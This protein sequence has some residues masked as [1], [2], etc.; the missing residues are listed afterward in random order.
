M[1]LLQNTSDVLPDIQVVIRHADAIRKLDARRGSSSS[2]S[3]LA[4]NQIGKSLKIFRSTINSKTKKISDA[5]DTM[6]VP[7]MPKI[8]KSKNPGEKSPASE[9]SYSAEKPMVEIS[10]SAEIR[11]EAEPVEPPKPSKNI[12]SRGRE[13]FRSMKIKNVKKP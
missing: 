2:V 6:K 13:S 12:F 1:R 4:K 8:S 10:K 5:F 7:N 3:S 11:P 9:I